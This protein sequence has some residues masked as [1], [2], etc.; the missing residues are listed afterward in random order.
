VGEHRPYKAT[1]VGSNPSA[2]TSLKEETMAIIKLI[3]L[4]NTICT[5]ACCIIMD[6]KGRSVFSGALLGLLLGPIGLLVCVCLSR[7]DDVIANELIASGRRKR[8]DECGSLISV[9]ARRCP[10]CAYAQSML[11]QLKEIEK[12]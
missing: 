1:V 10:F 7:D 5:I 8:C 9:E 12:I 2:G 6:S 3:I 4:I 11:E